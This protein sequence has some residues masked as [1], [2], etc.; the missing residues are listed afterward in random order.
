MFITV[1]MIFMMLS[2]LAGCI[3]FFR[4][5][6]GIYLRVLVFFL[7]YTIINE[8]VAGFFWDSE[9][10]TNLLYNIYNIVNGSCYLFILY[11]FIRQRKV[12]RVVLFIVL[13]YFAFALLNL[14]FFQGLKTFN[15]ISFAISSLL[16]IL[17]CVYYFL[18]LFL[19]TH[20]VYLV[21]EPS[22]WI[23]TGLL[24][25]FTCSFPLIA[26]SNFMWELPGIIMDNLRV[27]LQ[28]M[29]ILLYSLFAIAFLCKIKL[30]NSI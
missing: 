23:V 24:F 30:R 13:S 19:L 17:L 7:L 27:F 2:L 10:G 15:T 1:D 8:W 12:K 26:T 29:N 3:V 18:E 21:R 25:Y 9:G 28:L 22:F 4:R 5:D 20:Y 14:F 11:S 6:T 16:V